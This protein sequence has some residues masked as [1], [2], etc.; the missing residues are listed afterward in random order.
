MERKICFIIISLVIITTVTSSF[1]N[2]FPDYGNDNKVRVWEPVMS[3]NILD[4]LYNFLNNNNIT[5]CYEFE[6][7]QH[8]LLLKCWSNE[9]VV[10]VSVM[11]RNKFRFLQ[12]SPNPQPN[13]VLC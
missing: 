8:H 3:N 12:I 1:Y 9:Y 6:E 4:R 10:D 2:E 11:A 7:E 13:Y 5:N